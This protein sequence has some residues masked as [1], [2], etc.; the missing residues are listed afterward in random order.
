MRFVHVCTN[1]RVY[2]CTYL[3]PCHRMDRYTHTER[4]EEKEAH[5]CH[6]ESDPAYETS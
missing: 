4:R 6:T 1:I 3:V 5:A 2:A